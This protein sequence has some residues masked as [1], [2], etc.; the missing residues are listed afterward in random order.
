MTKTTFNSIKFSEEQDGYYLIGYR[1]ALKIFNKK[2][3][4]LKARVKE[5]GFE[6]RTRSGFFGISEEEAKQLNDAKGGEE[7]IREANP[8]HRSNKRWHPY[9]ASL[10]KAQLRCLHKIHTREHR[11]VFL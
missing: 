7:S 11:S 3:H 5:G 9:S 8:N 1:P 6:V 10:R 4:K 2:F